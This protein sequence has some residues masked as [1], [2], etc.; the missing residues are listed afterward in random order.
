M[1]KI[2]NGRFA[3]LALSAGFCVQLGHGAEPARFTIIDQQISQ[4][5]AQVAALEKQVSDF[6]SGSGSWNPCPDAQQS[7]V[8]NRSCQAIV[9][10]DAR[11]CGSSPK[12]GAPDDCRALYWDMISSK[13]LITAAADPAGARRLCLDMRA[14]DENN[15]RHPVDA[16][17]FCDVYLRYAADA[18]ERLL[19]LAPLFHIS[20]DSDK[21]R[22]ML[23][24]REVKERLYMGVEDPGR[25]A[26]GKN[27]WLDQEICRTAHGYRTSYANH[28]PSLCGRSGLCRALMGQGGGSCDYYAGSPAG[29]GSCGQSDVKQLTRS[30]TD[31]RQ[32]LMGLVQSLDNVEPRGQKG[33]ASR[34]LKLM[35]LHKECGGML[36]AIGSKDVKPAPVPDR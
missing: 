23:A 17:A 32:G 33:I 27:D 9:S 22:A 14:K 4:A 8:L 15:L 34:R 12:S 13:V 26:A 25:C 19:K 10:G 21:S 5:A 31:A 28:D 7:S 24:A 36:R 6:R 35:S 11:A 1:R 3:A 30:L 16:N 18:H 20:A 2:M 29:N